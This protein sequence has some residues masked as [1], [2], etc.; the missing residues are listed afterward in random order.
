MNQRIYIGTLKIP[1]HFDANTDIINNTR[2]YFKISFI[3]DDVLN[4][5]I[6]HIKDNN[7]MHGILVSINEYSLER[8]CFDYNDGLAFYFNKVTKTPSRTMYDDILKCIECNELYYN[9]NGDLISSEVIVRPSKNDIIIS[10]DLYELLEC[11]CVGEYSSKFKFNIKIRKKLTKQIL[12][13]ESRNITLILHIDTFEDGIIDQYVHIIDEP[14]DLININ[15][16]ENSIFNI[17]AYII[18]DGVIQKIG[19]SN[20]G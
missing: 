6:K 2:R 7:I 20:N 11:H 5:A 3:K 12:H 8:F 17:E 16:D 4:D 13:K 10:Y 14:R 1:D 18:S 19:G 9:E 15:Y